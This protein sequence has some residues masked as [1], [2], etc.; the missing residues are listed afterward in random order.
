MKKIIQSSVLFLVAA[1]IIGA[2]YSFSTIQSN[3]D[4]FV[5][6]YLKNDCSHDVKVYITNSGGGTL[7]TVDDKT[8]KPESLQPGQKIYDENQRTLIAEITASSEGKTIVVCQ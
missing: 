5:K 8:S 4:G 7:F 1:S 3:D 2:S 6:V